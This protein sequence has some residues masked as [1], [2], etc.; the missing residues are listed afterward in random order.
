MVSILSE[1]AKAGVDVRIIGKMTRRGTGLNARRLAIRLHTRTIIRDG[2]TVFLGSQSLRELELD[3]R[4]EV[5][6]IFREPKAVGAILRIFEEDWESHTQD[7]PVEAAAGGPV[8]KLAKRVA[9]AVAEELPPVGPVV[10]EVVKEMGA[11]GSLEVDLSRVDEVV[12]DAVK[13][14][15]KEAVRDVVGDGAALEEEP[16]VA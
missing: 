10:S 3:E 11:E 12:K 1:R 2:K 16:N 14:A 8:R 9:K 15:V 6:I 13:Q 7:A 4:R 5:G